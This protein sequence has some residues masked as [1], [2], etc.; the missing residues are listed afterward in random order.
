MLLLTR[1]VSLKPQWF[2]FFLVI[3]YGDKLKIIRHLAKKLETAFKIKGGKIEI[4]LKS[5]RNIF[6]VIE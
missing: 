2:M 4:S 1:L 3:L 5:M 6:K